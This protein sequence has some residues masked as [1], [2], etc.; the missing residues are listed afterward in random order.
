MNGIVD[1]NLLYENYEVV[2][3]YI[4]KTE[5]NGEFP[6]NLYKPIVK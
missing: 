3:T 5:T 1:N 4:L 2:D 6:V